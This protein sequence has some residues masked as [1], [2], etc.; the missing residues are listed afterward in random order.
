MPDSGHVESLLQPGEENRKLGL[1][2]NP[3]HSQFGQQ[4]RGKLGG[5]RALGAVIGSFCP[6]F[7]Q[8]SYP[9]PA[10]CANFKSNARFKGVKF[11]GQPCNS[12]D[13]V[14]Q[15]NF[16]TCLCMCVLKLL[17]LK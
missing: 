1:H 7:V 3:P 11:D 13:S 12:E 9:R 16:D 2:Q 10:D 14:L 6:G 15:K 5:F 17:L 8:Q 4:L